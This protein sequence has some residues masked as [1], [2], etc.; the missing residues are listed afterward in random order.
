MNIPTLFNRHKY[1]CINYE[2]AKNQ[3]KHE[4]ERGIGLQGTIGF[5]TTGC[6]K[7]EGFNTECPK[8]QSEKTL[9]GL[10]TH[11]RQTSWIATVESFR[12]LSDKQEEGERLLDS[13]HL[14]ESSAE[15][16]AKPRKAHQ[17]DLR[18]FGE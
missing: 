13:Q 10:T 2:Q 3:R 12:A 6:Y 7:C 11:T 4:L 15:N 8:Y 1:Q 18:G 5:E 9:E 16:Y 17:I 14:G